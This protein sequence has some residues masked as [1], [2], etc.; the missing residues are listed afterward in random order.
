[1]EKQ[2]H[3]EKMKFF[4]SDAWLIVSI[5][6]TDNGNGATLSSILSAGDYINHAIFSGSELRG[7]FAKLKLAGYVS[8]IDGKYYITGEA[9]AFR[10][11]KKEA[12]KTIEKTMI[13]FS[14]FLDVSDC[15]SQSSDAEVGQ[16]NDSGPTDEMIQQ[17]YKEYWDRNGGSLRPSRNANSV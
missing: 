13:D 7:G 2:T 6:I 15:D 14:K 10:D 17:A 5:A 4:W 11:S 16:Y 9:K 1:M 3:E 8:E 12:R